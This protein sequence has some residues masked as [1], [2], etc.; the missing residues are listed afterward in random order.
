MA[1]DL[2][3][4]KEVE[5]EGEETPQAAATKAEKALVAVDEKTRSG[6]EE[7]NKTELAEGAGGEG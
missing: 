5:M 1:L 2:E 4:Q 7:L 3:T 6:E